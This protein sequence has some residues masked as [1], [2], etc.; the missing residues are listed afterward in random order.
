VTTDPVGWEVEGNVAVPPP[1]IVPV[2][3]RSVQE[4]RG[5]RVIA[6]LPG[7]GWRGDLR[8]DSPV[9]QGSQTYIPA[10]PELEWYRSEADQVEVF[11]PLVPIERV[12]VETVASSS[13]DISDMSSPRRL[14]SLDA[15][16]IQ[17]P[18]PARDAHTLTGR[19]VIRAAAGYGSDEGEFRGLRAVTEPYTNR[20]GRVSAR[21]SEELEWYRWAWAGKPPRT[22]ELDLRVLWLE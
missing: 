7:L 12:W 2:P 11:A 5:R 6:G 13:A 16:P 1:P 21:V 3:A 4:I 18:L 10:L 8:A 20:E 19:R 15:P 22:M 17:H 9:I 14:R